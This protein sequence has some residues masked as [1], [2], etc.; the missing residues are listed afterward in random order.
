MGMLVQ[1][2]IAPSWLISFIQSLWYPAW[3]QDL[4]DVIQLHTFALRN[5][6]SHLVTLTILVQSIFY[7]IGLLSADEA[8]HNM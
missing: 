6:L 7:F 2:P 4:R 5:Q 3:M 8:L 1:E